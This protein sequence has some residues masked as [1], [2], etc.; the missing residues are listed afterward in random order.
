[1]KQVLRWIA[2]L[3]FCWV[4]YYF[5]EVSSKYLFGSTDPL[6]IFFWLY[7]FFALCWLVVLIKVGN[8]IAR[9]I[10]LDSPLKKGQHWW[11]GQQG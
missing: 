10:G 8:W 6:S 11:Y 7:I 5:L 1:M 2:L 3:A 9:V 4:A